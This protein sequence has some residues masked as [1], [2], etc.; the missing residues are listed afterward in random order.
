M[1]CKFKKEVIILLGH[2]SPE[3]YAKK[4]II[5]LKKKLSKY[6]KKKNV[7][8]YHAFLQFNKPSLNSCLQKVLNSTFDI[9]AEGEARQRRQSLKIIIL[10]VF[11]SH[12][13][14]TLHDIPK[15]INEFKK[16]YN[17]VFIKLALPLGSD[18]LMAELL[19]KRI[20]TCLEVDI[21]A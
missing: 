3:K 1:K 15:V 18:D 13:R 6:F 19:N 9:P 20:S 4:V 11:I 8:I 14:H 7:I 10:P 12:G 2:G 21:N 17:G 5:S 16:K